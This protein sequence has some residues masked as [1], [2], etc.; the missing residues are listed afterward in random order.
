M[1]G[2]NTTGVTVTNI[3]L[4]AAVVLILLTAVIAMLDEWIT[5]IRKRR[6]IE[7]ELNRDMKHFFRPM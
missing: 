4:G 7:A 1:N 5:R 2:T 6:S 3:V